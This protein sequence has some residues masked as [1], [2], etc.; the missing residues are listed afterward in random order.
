MLIDV[1]NGEIVDKYTI[2]QLK[3]KFISLDDDKYTHAQKESRIL[4]QHVNTIILKLS[5]ID[6]TNVLNIL[7]KYENLYIPEQIEQIYDILLTTNEKLWIIEDELRLKER[8]SEFDNDFIELAR[9]VY[10][11][12]D[13]RYKYKDMINLLTDSDII[14]TKTYV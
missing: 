2:L 4:E 3:L 14:E 10:K 11:T 13:L 9:S 1:S 5:Q 8:N 6:K 7:N 12:N